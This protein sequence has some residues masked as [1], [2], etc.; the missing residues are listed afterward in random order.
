MDDDVDLDLDEE[1][2]DGAQVILD[3]LEEVISLPGDQEVP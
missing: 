2:N 3:D 1:N